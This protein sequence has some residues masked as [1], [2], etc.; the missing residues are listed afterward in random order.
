M[1]TATHSYSYSLAPH[2]CRAVN[3]FLRATDREKDEKS[4]RSYE[5]RA[6]LY[7]MGLKLIMLDGRQA[8]ATP[9]RGEANEKELYH[10]IQTRQIF[11]DHVPRRW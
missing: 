6:R 3:T 9:L 4:E 5:L 11:M 10:D 1:A 7:K 2:T 8:H